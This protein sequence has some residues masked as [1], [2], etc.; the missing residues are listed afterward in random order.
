MINVTKLYCEES[1]P[2]DSI[3]YGRFTDVEDS[4]VSMHSIPHSADTRKPVVVWNITRTC[5]LHCIHCYSSSD[6]LSYSGEFSTDEVKHVLKDLKEF[7]IPALLFSGGEP[8]VRKD[9]F[10]LADFAKSLGIRTTLSTN[11]TLITPAVAK[12]IKNSGFIYAGISLDGIGSVN[13]FFRGKRGAF[14]K[15]VSGIRNCI[16]AGQRAGLRLTL[17]KHNYECLEDIFDFIEREGLERACFY[18][19]A[20]SGRGNRISTD[21]L[22]HRETRDAVLKIMKIARNFSENKKGIEV[23]TVDNHVDGILI[24]L[25][26][27]KENKQNQAQDVL[28]MLKWNGGGLY[29]SGVGVADIDFTGNVHADQFW[30]HY[31]FGNV[32][33]RKFSDIWM[34]ETDQ[35][36]HYLK[37]KKKYIKGK[38]KHCKW[39]NQCGGSLRVR[40]DMVYNDPMAPDPACYPTDIECGISPR[41]RKKIDGKSLFLIPEG[42][43]T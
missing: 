17:T 18:H 25:S 5:N 22:T 33:E 42:L 14:K 31:S 35:L 6:N 1:T 12:K 20:Y 2:G 36:M 24:Y 11:G 19:L 29:S 10:E 21:D 23:L 27:L 41:L 16:D 39:L 37:H 9:I 43:T 32:R 15:T 30:M 8:L 7:G 28:D 34:D 4:N 38:C 13:D 26:L 40:A 3:R